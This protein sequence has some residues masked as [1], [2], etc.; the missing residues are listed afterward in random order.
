MLKLSSHT[1]QLPIYRTAFVAMEDQFGLARQFAEFDELVLVRD[2]NWADNAAPAVYK[3]KDRFL[4][5][6][7]RN[8]SV[9]LMIVVP[10]MVRRCQG[11]SV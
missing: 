4:Y 6:D 5:N 7:S 3:T 11:G 2:E 9:S 10:S 1:T 8:K